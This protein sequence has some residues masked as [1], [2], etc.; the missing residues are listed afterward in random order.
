MY[1][2]IHNNS[3]WLF[4]KIAKFFRG[5]FWRARYSLPRIAVEHGPLHLSV[6]G[7]DNGGPDIDE[8]DKNGHY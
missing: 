4:K 7:V 3:L 8:R 6:T 2:I 5:T 1:K